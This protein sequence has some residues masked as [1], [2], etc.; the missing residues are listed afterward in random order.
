MSLLSFFRMYNK[1]MSTYNNPT[2]RPNSL[3]SSSMF[4]PQSSSGPQQSSQYTPTLNRPL[5]PTLDHSSSEMTSQPIPKA[6]TAQS[7][8]FSPQCE[9]R[10][11]LGGLGRL[12]SMARHVNQ[13]QT[14]ELPSQKR[15]S[16]DKA[17]FSRAGFPSKDGNSYASQ[18][19]FP[20]SPNRPT[21]SEEESISTE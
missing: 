6:M 13:R 11:A 14:E 17:P 21:L 1:I 5:R 16:C 4:F 18:F 8:I 7:A 20:K 10:P 3:A 15:N 9:G 19:F 12:D 2:L